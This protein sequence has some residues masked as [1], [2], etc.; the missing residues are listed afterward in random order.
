ME[1]RHRELD[2]DNKVQ[3]SEGCLLRSFKA[4]FRRSY[5]IIKVTKVELPGEFLVYNYTPE[6]VT[7]YFPEEFSENRIRLLEEYFILY[8]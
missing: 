6:Y 3:P 8:I 5:S 7:T 4:L 1:W 2:V